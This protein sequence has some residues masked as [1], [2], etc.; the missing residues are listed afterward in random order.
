MCLAV[1]SRIVEI[2]D[3]VATVDVDGV[4]REASLMLLD[5]V[6]VGDYVIVHAGFAI[7]RIDEEVAEQTLKDMRDMVR[8][9]SK[10]DEA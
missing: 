10:G 1:P 9:V 2:K 3:Q 8:F 4:T 6:S 7:E 5:N